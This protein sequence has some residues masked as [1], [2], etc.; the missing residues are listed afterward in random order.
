MASA[1][2]AQ[3]LLLGILFLAGQHGPQAILDAVLVAAE[4]IANHRQSRGIGVQQLVIQIV[5]VL[6]V[7]ACQGQH[8][9]E[10]SRSSRLWTPSTFRSAADRPTAQY[11]RSCFTISGTCGVSALT[12]VLHQTFGLRQLLLLDNP[13]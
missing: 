4:R 1:A 5:N 6:I 3:S 2:A 9:M 10:S 8:E 11:S 13:C 7:L 12:R